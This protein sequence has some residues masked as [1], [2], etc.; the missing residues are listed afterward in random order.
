MT[1][2]DNK[3]TVKKSLK[4]IKKLDNEMANQKVK[5]EHC[6]HTIVMVDAERTICSHC[7][8]WVYKDE[9]TK[10]KFKM[11]EELRKWKK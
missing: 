2:I 11:K 7:G 6:G 5:C 8:Y 3:F 9:K 1:T 10:F 4:D